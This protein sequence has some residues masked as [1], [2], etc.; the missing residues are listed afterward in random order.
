LTQVQ[1]ALEPYGVQFQGSDTLAWDLLEEI[2]TTEGACFLVTNG[3]IERKIQAFSSEFNRS[4]SLLA[5]SG[6][7][8]V[9]ISGIL[10]HRVKG[11][12]PDQDTARKVATLRPIAGR[13][14]DT[15]S[16]LGY[17]AIE[18]IRRGAQSVLT[19]ELDPTMHDIA[20]DNPWSRELF[21][22]ARIERAY[23]D[24][25]D[26]LQ[27]LPDRSFV[28]VIHDPPVLSLAGQLYSAEFYA[29]LLRV[30]QRGGRLFHYIGDLDS[31]SG[32]TVAHGVVRRLQEVG[33]QRVT[34]RPEAFGLLATT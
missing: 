18:A 33:F 4:Y 30:L 1:V 20:R 24:A 27:D 31:R 7:P 17:T 32:R 34:R 23:G 6:A 19:I 13:V 28:R 2:A 5:T 8:T 9:M 15:A 10:M 26:L 14:L 11:I 22:D 25:F 16:G 12:T 21:S 3:S 29:Q